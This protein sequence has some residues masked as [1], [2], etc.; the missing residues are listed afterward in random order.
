MNHRIYKEDII[1]FAKNEKE[2]ESLIQ[3]VKIYSA[4]RG[5]DFGIEKCA[6]PI[7]KTEDDKQR[8]K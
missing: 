3:A 8:K 6:V 7:M 5:M 4:E 2:L 1:L